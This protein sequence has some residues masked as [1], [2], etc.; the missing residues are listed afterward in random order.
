MNLLEDITHFC[1]LVLCIIHCTQTDLICFLRSLI[2]DLLCLISGI[3]QNLVCTNVGK[4]CDLV[5]FNHT[6]CLIYGLCNNRIGTGSCISKNHFLVT[7]N[8]L[9]TFNLAWKL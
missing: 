5:L 9:T 1:K 3:L 6:I 4:T 8:L 7:H 2:Y